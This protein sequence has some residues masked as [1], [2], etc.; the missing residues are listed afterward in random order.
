[1]ILDAVLSELLIG[2]IFKLKRQIDY[3]YPDV[4]T[5]LKIYGSN[6]SCDTVNLISN[7]YT[8]LSEVVINNFVNSL[9]FNNIYLN[10][11]IG[12]RFVFFIGFFG[13]IK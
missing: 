8:L 7:S 12:Y 1:M 13:W 3:L 2:F 4:Y 9:N 10:N 11:Y 5:K 6:I